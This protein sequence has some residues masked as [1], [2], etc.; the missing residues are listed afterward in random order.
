MT[1]DFQVFVI[2]TYSTRMGNNEWD[3]DT[4]LEPGVACSDFHLVHLLDLN[5]Y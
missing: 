5:L 2:L 4:G 3:K 1:G